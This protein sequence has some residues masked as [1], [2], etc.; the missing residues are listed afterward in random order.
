[1]GRGHPGLLSQDVGPDFEV[2]DVKAIDVGE[3]HVESRTVQPLDA[4][5]LT[6]LNP[7][8]LEQEWPAILVFVLPFSDPPLVAQAV[9]DAVA[10]DGE[11]GAILESEEVLRRIRSRVDVRVRAVQHGPLVDERRRFPNAI[12]LENDIGQIGV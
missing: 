8:Q 11:V 2:V 4:R 12:N 6:S 1:M 5:H 7:C 9:D 10:S 3:F